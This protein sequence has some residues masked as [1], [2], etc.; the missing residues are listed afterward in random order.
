MAKMAGT[1]VISA[2]TGPIKTARRAALMVLWG[3]TLYGCGQTGPLYLPKD[4][5]PEDAQASL[6]RQETERQETKQLE[7]IPQET[8]ESRNTQ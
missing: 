3:W 7:K 5:P 4:Q 8:Q 6:D 1:V 2:V